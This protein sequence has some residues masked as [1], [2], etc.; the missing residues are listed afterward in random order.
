MTT[1]AVT[2]ERPPR[3]AFVLLA[4]VVGAI[5]ANINLSIANVALPTIGHDL[6][7][8]Q[9]ELTGIANA[10]ALGLASTVLYLGTIGD[11]YGRKL[12]F[13]L[14]ATLTIPTA[15]LA[16]F[17]PNAEVLIGA[18]Y[19]GGIAAALLFPTT[20]S[21][22]NA[23][24]RGK[25]KVSAIAMWSGLGGGVAALGPLLG[26]WLLGSFWWGSV[27]LITLPLDVLAQFGGPEMV[28]GSVR[29]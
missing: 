16:A 25:A 6:N 18:R 5:V 17:A 24:Y 8:S 19:L 1:P 23:L 28:R 14:G 12:L 22:I 11:R 27:F 29:L 26:G 7:A 9:D 13:V 4:L 3:S 15:F 10:F 20:L 2:A 21:L